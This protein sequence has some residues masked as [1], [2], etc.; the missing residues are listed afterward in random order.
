GAK[1]AN[2]HLGMNFG[3]GS[4]P[5]RL[6]IKSVSGNYQKTDVVCFEY[7]DQ[8]PPEFGVDLELMLEK[9]IKLPLSR[10]LEPI[11][12]SWTDVDPTRTTLSDFF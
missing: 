2:E 10:I 12:W 5:K 8:V 1:Y 6:Y 3:K 11:G 9:T 7:G 4:K